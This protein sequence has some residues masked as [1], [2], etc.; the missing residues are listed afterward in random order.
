M[1]FFKYF[2][3]YF[4]IYFRGK[5]FTSLSSQHFLHLTPQSFPF[6]VVDCA[7]AMRFLWMSWKVSL[8]IQLLRFLPSFCRSYCRLCSIQWMYQ[9]RPQWPT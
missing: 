3:K 7:F 5:S 9:W 8:E 1:K 2:M 4:M 6:L